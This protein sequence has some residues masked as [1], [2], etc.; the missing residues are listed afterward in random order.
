MQSSLPVTYSTTNVALAYELSRSKPESPEVLAMYCPNCGTQVKD[1]ATFCTGCGMRLESKSGS[2]VGEPMPTRSSRHTVV[3]PDEDT[4]V[5]A[6]SWS[7]EPQV[8][9][10]QTI[11]QPTQ[12]PPSPTAFQQTPG[13]F[14]QGQSQPMQPVI[15]QQVPQQENYNTL[16]IV[17]LVISAISLG[18]GMYDGALIGLG[19]LIVS[20]V[21]LV[22]CR[23]KNEKGT[24]LAIIG[25][26]CGS[27]SFL[28]AL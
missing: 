26:V 15:P 19:G 9:T 20:I 13:V 16:C 5:T 4:N 17:G 3:P 14:T 28:Y 8:P 27:I 12:V 6:T 22:N 2:S 7:Q 24:I 23:T 1:G 18:L 25:I 21:G 10:Q 11:R